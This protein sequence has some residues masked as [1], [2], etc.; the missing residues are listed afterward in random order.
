MFRLLKRHVSKYTVKIVLNIILVCAQ[1]IIQIYFLAHEMKAIIDCG[2]AEGNMEA[3]AQSGLRMVLFS[4]ATA[5]LALFASYFSSSITAGITGD[6]RESCY[7]KVLGMTPQDFSSFGESTLLTRT[8]ADATQIQI[9]IIN[10]MR[11]SLMVPIVIVI[12]LISVFLMNKTIFEIIFVVFVCSIL[13]LTIMGAKSKP[14]FNK[15]QKQL[16]R[17]N[18]LVKEKITGARTI[19]SFGNQE[20]EEAKLEK[21]IQGAYDMAIAANNR[22]N[23]LSPVAMIIMNWMVV[24]IYNVGS[25]QLKL[26]LASISDMLV[27][28]QYVT[29]FIT[30]LAVIPM[31]LN[32]IPKVV[33]SSERINDLL[34]YEPKVKYTGSGEPRV[35]EGEIEFQNV[36]FGYDEGSR[37][38]A[39][40]SFV[41][42]KGKT[43]AFIGATGS[44]KSTLMN[45]AL[46][47]FHPNSG[48]ILID[49]ISYEDIDI[50]ALKKHFSYASQSASVFQ[51]TAYKNIAMYDDCI[52]RKRVEEACRASCFDE[53]I[54]K[55]P[56]GIETIMAQGGK[57]ISGGQRQRL[58]LARTVVRN[59]EVYIFDDTFSALD[60]STE[61]KARKRIKEMLAGK[62]VLMVAQKI[63]TIKDADQILVL[64]HGAIVG[65]GTHSELMESCDIYKEIYDTQCYLDGNK[66]NE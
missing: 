64:D 1:M 49:G 65:K 48:K 8:M 56:Q 30:T 50:D 22:I 42:K 53:V 7:K 51:D 66:Q 26:G 31:L 27:I 24:I 33:V 43:T 40:I 36:S 11:S 29:Y 23:F 54:E 21:E 41:A 62:T 28:F 45:L 3:I 52:D 6:L 57:N 47:F 15:L 20:F 18:L 35:T 17:L 38:I 37:T 44:G 63:N 10:F 59:A 32:L 13:F 9:L 25:N 60:A 4:V 19:R 58:S 5:V 55:M 61:Q 14:F 12:L 39:G 46:G 34:D 2:V 16:D